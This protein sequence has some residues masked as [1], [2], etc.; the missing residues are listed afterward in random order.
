MLKEGGGEQY[1]EKDEGCWN[2]GCWSVVFRIVK[3]GVWELGQDH[4]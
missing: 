4:R 2:P 1:Y 3:A